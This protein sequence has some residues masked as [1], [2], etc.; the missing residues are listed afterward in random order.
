MKKTY[1]VTLRIEDHING[2]TLL[3]SIDGMTFGVGVHID[4]DDSMEVKRVIDTQLELNDDNGVSVFE[5]C[6]FVTDFNCKFITNDTHFLGFVTVLLQPQERI[7]LE[8]YRNDTHKLIGT[9]Y[10][11]LTEFGRGAELVPN[12]DELNHLV[13]E[14]AREANLFPSE[15]YFKSSTVK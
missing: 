11:P 5:V 4:K 10:A 9:K 6:D 1:I 8:V 3:E 14:V 15:V 12:A 13:E 7:K 2:R